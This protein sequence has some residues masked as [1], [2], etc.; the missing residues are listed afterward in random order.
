MGGRTAGPVSPGVLKRRPCLHNCGRDILHSGL[1]QRRPAE[2][3]IVAQ[4]IRI[5][6]VTCK[7]STFYQYPDIAQTGMF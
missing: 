2:T 4:L 6:P 3:S 7:T 5:P 1:T